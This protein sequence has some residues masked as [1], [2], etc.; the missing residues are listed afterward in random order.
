MSTLSSLFA[1]A[2]LKNIALSQAA[3]EVGADRETLLEAVLYR[4]RISNTGT[5]YDMDYGR[6]LKTALARLEAAN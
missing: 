2:I 4:I 6:T 1:Q 3:S 5:E